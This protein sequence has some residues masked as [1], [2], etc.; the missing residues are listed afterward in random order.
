MMKHTQ[1]VKDRLR[2]LVPVVLAAA[3]AGLALTGCTRQ[4]TDQDIRYASLAAVRA[5][6]DNGQVLVLDPRSETKFGQGHLP[7][8]VNMS[9]AEVRTE[10]PQDPRLTAASRIYVYGDGP[11]N[12]L[13]RAMAKKLMAADFDDVFLYDGGVAEWVRLYELETPEQ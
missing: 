4:I 2:L 12:A 3:A 8:A 1:T 10:G 5:S 7:G 6:L 9:I 13:A 11:N